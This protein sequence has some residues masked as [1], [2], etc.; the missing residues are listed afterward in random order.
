MYLSND[1]KIATV[2]QYIYL[3]KGKKVKINNP[4]YNDLRNLRLL[5]HAYNIAFQYLNR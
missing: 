4:G 3:T 2:Q 1:E 5:N